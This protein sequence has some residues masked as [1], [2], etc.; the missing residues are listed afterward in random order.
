MKILS[1]ANFGF[2]M[3]LAGIVCLSVGCAP[4]EPEFVVTSENSSG[5]GGG[6]GDGGGRSAAD[7]AAG[8]SSSGGDSTADEE[9]LPHCKFVDTDLDNPDDLKIGTEVGQLVP[10]IHGP[11]LY[12]E[13]FKLSDYRGQVVMLDFYG[14]W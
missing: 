5:P 11:D 3:C 6:K 12:G 1:W 2:A 4:P 14:D 7:M 10:D 9:Q 8:A 13:E